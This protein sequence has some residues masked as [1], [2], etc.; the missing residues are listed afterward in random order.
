MVTTDDGFTL[1]VPLAAKTLQCAEKP[2]K[3]MGELDNKPKAIMFAVTLVKLLKECCSSSES[4]SVRV[5]REKMWEKY[6][7]LLSL[8]R[9]F[10]IM[11]SIY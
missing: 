6:Y 5:K 2:L 11:V 8:K 4:K 10:Y 9:F 3:W 1:P 7:Q